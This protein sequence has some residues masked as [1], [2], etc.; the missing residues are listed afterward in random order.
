M[1]ENKLETIMEGLK[2]SIWGLYQDNGKEA[3]N[4]Y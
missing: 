1:M 2:G 4:D 3:G